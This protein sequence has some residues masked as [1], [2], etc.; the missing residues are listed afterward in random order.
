MEPIRKNFT[1]LMPEP[2]D[3]GYE[4]GGWVPVTDL[5][6]QFNPSRGFVVTANQRMIPEDF[7]YKVGYEWTEPYRANR[8]TEVLSQYATSGRKITKQDMERLQGDVTS[9]PARE[10]LRLLSSVEP[11]ADD[12]PRQLLLRWN[13]VL[14]RDSAAAA[15]Y[16]LW[17][18]NV[19]SEMSQHLAPENTLKVIQNRVPMPVILN[20]LKNP[21]EETF[22][23]QPKVAR[24]RL[25]LDALKAAQGRMISLQGSDPSGWSWGRLHTITFHNPLEVLPN[26]KALVELGPIPR[27]GDSFTVNSTAYVGEN[28]DQVSGPSWREILDVGNWDNSEMVNTPA[29]SGEPGSPHYSDLMHLW[30][31]VRYFPMLYSRDAVEKEAKDRMLLDPQ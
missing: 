16:E 24:D 23:P 2:G 21:D 15:L 10:L 5:P 17:Q 7:P 30:D 26:V 25:L 11:N 29:E 27:P 14:D 6:H 1:G 28:F 3:G 19:V 18:I 13:D 8:I 22:G 20:H 12:M 9:V 4:W 31:Q